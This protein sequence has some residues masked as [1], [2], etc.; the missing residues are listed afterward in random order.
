[1]KNNLNKIIILG[2]SLLLLFLSFAIA[3]SPDKDSVFVFFFDVGQGDASLIQ[4]DD[5]QIVIDGGPD[6]K[7]LSLLG[8]KMPLYDRKIEALI[9]SHPHADHLIGLIPLLDRYEIGQIYFSG[10]A[11]NSAEYLSF[12]N[13]VKEKNISV[14]TPDVGY[15]LR[16]YD[17]AF[18]EF[19]WPGSKYI[20]KKADNPNN[21]SEV[22]RYCYLAK[23][24]FYT[25]DIEKDEQD[26][27]MKSLAGQNFTSIILKVPHHGSQNA[28][29]EN[30][31]DFVKPQFSIF[32]VGKNNQYGHPHQEAINLAKSKNSK[33]LR[34]DDR[35]TIE[36]EIH[37]NGDFVLDE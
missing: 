2:L 26:I 10:S 18:L 14:I 34:T 16:P 3:K 37:K 17:N 25:G 35:G 30:L 22:V 31:Y 27:M 29:N 21:V 32:S 8:E 11:Y 15:N 19:L 23:C 13:K 33:I 9:L 1:M 28:T 5:Y 7:I 6:D 36:F 12:L 24:V 4:K 20:K